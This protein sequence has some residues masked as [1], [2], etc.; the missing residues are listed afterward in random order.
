MKWKKLVLVALAAT[1]AIGAA[2]CGSQQKAD[3]GKGAAVSGSITGSG[4]SALLP[5][6]KDA[7]EKF[8]ANNKDV[9]ITLN[10][11]GSGTGLKHKHLVGNKSL[12][13]CITA[14]SGGCR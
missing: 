8:K 4:S 13:P 7:A 6:V 14:R 9:T 10:A 3:S 2:G 1:M 5:L 11:G 12:M